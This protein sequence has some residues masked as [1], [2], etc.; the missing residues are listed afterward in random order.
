MDKYLVA[1]LGIKFYFLKFIKNIKNY[2]HYDSL[3]SN[4]RHDDVYIVEFPKSG[5]TWLSFLI[6]NV[7]LQLSNSNRQITFYNTAQYVPDIHRSRDI[8]ERVASDIGFR[9]IKSHAPFNPF[10]Q[11]V[12]YLIRQPWDVMNSYYHFIQSFG[13]NKS[14]EE[15]VN[16][17]NL[18]IDAWVNHV[19]GW[20]AKG[21]SAQRLQLVRY[22]DLKNNPQKVLSEI[23]QNLG[24]SLSQEII[25]RAVELSSFENMKNS[26]AFY[27]NHN[28]NYS[29]EFV[30]QGKSTKQENKKID[31]MLI[32]K[33][34]HLENLFKNSL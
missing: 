1:F 11:H 5:V 23:Y 17:K 22:E 20:L 19:E 34:K 6:G 10:Y 8:P 21:N 12:I 15:F 13:Y 26:E 25:E 18:G 14:F 33:V 27:R 16:D 9:F 31:E 7:N 2:K 3:A 29:V 24:I 4:P 32:S 28:P 30:R